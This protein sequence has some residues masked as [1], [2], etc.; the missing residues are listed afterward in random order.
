[1]ARTITHQDNDETKPAL[2][3]SKDHLEVSQTKSF[4]QMIYET[5]SEKTPNG[6]ELKLFELILNISIDHGTGAP[7]AVATINAAKEGKSLS[8]SVAR[9][10]M[11]INTSHGGAIEPCMEILYRVKGK[12]VRVKA[13]VEDYLS[14]D[15]RMPGMG[16]RI[17]KDE[18]PRTKLIFE[19]MAEFGMNDEFI[20]IAKELESELETQKGK[21]LPINIDGAI[22]VLLCT[23]GWEPRLSNTVFICARVP[24][25][26]GQFLN[27][28]RG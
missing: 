18:D 20:K 5:L 17:Y 7:S 23:F 19:K 9:G 27:A 12:G 16:H 4:A 3:G 10:L 25:L 22:A 28:S 2:F 11:Q 6:E 13:L 1:M 24:G 15:K 8:E 14:Q 26:C 21:K